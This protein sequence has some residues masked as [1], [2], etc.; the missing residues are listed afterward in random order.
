MQQEGKVKW[1]DSE[2]GFGFITPNGGGKDV[3]LHISDLRD[4]GYLEVEQ[5]DLVEYEVETN[6]KGERAVN[7][8]IYDLV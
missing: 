1:F 5:G 8:T 2:R 3:F 4:S 6:Q 7:I